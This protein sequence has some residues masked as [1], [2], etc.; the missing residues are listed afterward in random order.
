VGDAH[1]RTVARG[2]R[3]LRSGPEG[4]GDFVVLVGELLGGLVHQAGLVVVQV[5]L[6]DRLDTVGAELDGHAEGS[7]LEAVLAVQQ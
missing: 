3:T 7:V 4:L 2:V 1:R 6:D 5:L